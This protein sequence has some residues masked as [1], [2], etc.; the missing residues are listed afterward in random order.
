M[1]DLTQEVHKARGAKATEAGMSS[2]AKPSLKP[3]LRKQ[4]QVDTST[5]PSKVR[6]VSRTPAL[7]SVPE[8]AESFIEA[9]VV[10]HKHGSQ[11]VVQR[12]NSSVEM[13][14]DDDSHPKSM[15][16]DHQQVSSTDIPADVKQVA[17]NDS[18]PVDM[19]TDDNSLSVAIEA[20][21]KQVLSTDKAA[22]TI[23]FQSSIRQQTMLRW[24]WVTMPLIVVEGTRTVRGCSLDTTLD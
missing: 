12:G 8:M 17:Q 1:L 7:V 11:E 14:T 19:V 13:V 21:P 24:I 22:G 16:A 6:H 10:E 4:I 20:I 5:L 18:G 3:N 2:K 15:D 9:V 23:C